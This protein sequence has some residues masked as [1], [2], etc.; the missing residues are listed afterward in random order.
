MAEGG[1]HPS[2]N[3]P[4]TENLLVTVADKLYSQH[5]QNFATTLIGLEAAEYNDIVKEAGDDPGKQCLEVGILFR[6]CWP[7]NLGLKLL[8]AKSANFIGAR[9]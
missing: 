9:N 7:N 8:E 6:A 5:L 1:E 2:V 3:S 4:V